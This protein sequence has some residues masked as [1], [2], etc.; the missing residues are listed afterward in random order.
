MRDTGGGFGRKVL[1]Q[2]EDMCVLLAAVRL[3]PH[4]SGSRNGGSILLAAGQARHEHGEARTAFDEDSRILAATLDHVQDAGACPTPSPVQ[5]G[6]AAVHALPRPV[7]H[8]RGHLPPR[9]VF[10]NTSGRVAYRGPWQYESMARKALPDTAARQLGME[11]PGGLRR[12]NLLRQDEP[13]TAHFIGMPYDHISPREA[14]EQALMMLD[15]EAFREQQSRPCG[16]GRYRCPLRKRSLRSP[17][18]VPSRR[19]PSWT[20]TQGRRSP[21]G[22][23][24]GLPGRA[25]AGQ[26]GARER[27]I[28]RSESLMRQCEPFALLTIASAP[29]AP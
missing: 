6:A 19:S 15:D 22:R 3:P 4:S 13:P 1:P 16:E 8:T 20:P 28:P 12:R 23:M 7:P 5:S 10:S 2:R 17:S 29:P 24:R 26:P 21:A 27:V 9:F 25:T 14:L 18:S 11:P